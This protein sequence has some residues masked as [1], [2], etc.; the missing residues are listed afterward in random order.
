MNTSQN[1]W[2]YNTI[3]V[4]KV[5]RQILSFSQAYFALERFFNI[6]IKLLLMHSDGK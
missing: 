2:K 3:L 1:L 4:V 5:K 6:Y